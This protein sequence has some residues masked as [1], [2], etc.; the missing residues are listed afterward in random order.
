[1]NW[2]EICL[3]L[4]EDAKRV[5]L[6][7]SYYNHIT[8]DTTPRE[9]I[10]LLKC[11]VD[12]SIAHKWPS[13][14]FIKQHF[15]RHMLVENGLLIDSNG[16]FP[17]QDKNRRFNYMGRYL[18]LGESNAT[19]KYSFR[20]HASKIWVFDN[21]SVS[22]DAKYGASFEV[23]LYDNA[24]ADITTDL[25]SKAKVIRHSRNTR[26]NKTGIVTIIDEFFYLE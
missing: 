4:R 24:Y 1:M 6:P 19:I 12:F 8:E 15:Q 5:G 14:S 7:D 25:V 16:T 26:V 11:C 10:T 20:P 18:L 22:L 3:K 17:I 23:H 13:T 9:I 2:N 21:S